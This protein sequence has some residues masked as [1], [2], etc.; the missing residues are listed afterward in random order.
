[1]N[2]NMLYLIAAC[3]GYHSAFTSSDTKFYVSDMTRSVSGGAMPSG[4]VKKKK[5]IIKH[6]TQNYIEKYNRAAHVVSM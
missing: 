4:S 6:T 5:K 2:F 1:M 3:F